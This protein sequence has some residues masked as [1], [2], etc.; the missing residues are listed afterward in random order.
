MQEITIAFKYSATREQYFKEAILA[1]LESTQA[2]GRKNKLVMLSETR[3]SVRGES[4]STVKDGLFPFIHTVSSLEKLQVNNDDKANGLLTCILQFYFIV[5]LFIVASALVVTGILSSKLQYNTLD[6]ND[7]SEYA[8]V[9][10][11]QLQKWADE[12]NEQPQAQTEFDKI[13][14]EACDV[15]LRLEVEQDWPREM[16]RQ[17]QQMAL[18]LDL[19]DYFKKNV[20][21]PFLETIIS[22]IDTRLVLSEPHFRATWLLPSKL[23]FSL[24]N[25]QLVLQ[26]LPIFSE[27]SPFYDDLIEHGDLNS[28]E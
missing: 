1:D 18:F 11:S 10:K 4:F 27:A 21:L 8:N 26:L 3:W 23:N 28:C 16:R 25:E 2:L 24:S 13:Y 5:T 15:S 22:Q 20:F 6:L 9:C 12:V 14:S 19:K 17:P 7:A